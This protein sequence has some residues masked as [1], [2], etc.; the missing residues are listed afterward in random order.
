MI[1]LQEICYENIAES[2]TSAPPLIQEMVIGETKK[3]IR[4]KIKNELSRKIELDVYNALPCLVPEIMVDIIKTMT[5]NNRLRKNYYDIYRNLSRDVID[6]A[7]ST[8]EQ[9]VNSLGDR[10]IESLSRTRSQRYYEYSND[11]DDEDDEDD[12]EAED[13]DERY[14]YIIPT[15]DIVS[16]TDR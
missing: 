2:I 12:E 15:I 11:E 1:S 6:C 16:S 13:Y 7:V 10:Y 5:Q 9:C 4:N 14:S 3:R 8:A